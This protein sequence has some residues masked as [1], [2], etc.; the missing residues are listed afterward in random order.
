LTSIGGQAATFTR[1][2]TA[3]PLDVTGTARTVQNHQPAFE[4]IDLDGDAARETPALLLGT[5]D[6]IWWPFDLLP[7]AL[8]VYLEFIEKG[9]ATNLDDSVCYIGNAGNT[10]ARLWVDST[11][12]F[13]R[14]RH[15]NGTSDVT[16]T[17]AAAP[18][19]GQRVALRVTLDSSGRVQIHQSINGAAETS[20]SQS[21][22]N[23]LAAAWGA[24]RLY[25][26][27]TGDTNAG[28]VCHVRIRVETG[29]KTA[30]QMQRVW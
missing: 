9:A 4:M 26:N 15:D 18:S 19:T 3:A 5:S 11:G 8:T 21:G 23:A 12:S 27:S 2:A 1:A 13:Y 6:K 25:A 7:Q 17:L 22:T 24:S 16:S 20:A 30:T 28:A 10:G 29:N 14:A